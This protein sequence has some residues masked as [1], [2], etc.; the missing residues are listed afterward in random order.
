MEEYKETEENLLDNRKN[1]N[2]D[3]INKNYSFDSKNSCVKHFKQYHKRFPYDFALTKKTNNKY[4]NQK[5]LNCCKCNKNNDNDNNN[6]QCRNCIDYKNFLNN[7]ENIREIEEGNENDFTTTELFQKLRYEECM[8]C[9]YTLASIITSLIYYECKK[10]NLNI[11]LM[12]FTLTIISLF[13]ILFCKLI[14]YS[15]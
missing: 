1:T 7:I 12:I 13:N 11:D 8:S 4:N 10:F 6:N 5:K 3:T 9:I 2:Q 15:N 14:I